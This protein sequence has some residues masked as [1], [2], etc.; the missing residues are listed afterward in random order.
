MGHIAPL[1]FAGWGQRAVKEG[2]GGINII[3]TR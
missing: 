1:I 2:L 3:E